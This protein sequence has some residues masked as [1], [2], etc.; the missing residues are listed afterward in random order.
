MTHGRSKKLTLVTA[1]RTMEGDGHCPSY[2]GVVTQWPV[3]RAGTPGALQIFTAAAQLETIASCVDTLETLETHWRHTECCY[4]TSRPGVE[5]VWRPGETA[6]IILAHLTLSSTIRVTSR[7]TEETQLGH[8][9]RKQ[10][11]LECGDIKCPHC[12]REETQGEKKFCQ[13]EL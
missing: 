12:T 4:E 10:K 7:Y 1:T 6:G 2:P 5:T 11:H 13:R 3:A 9:L 8:L